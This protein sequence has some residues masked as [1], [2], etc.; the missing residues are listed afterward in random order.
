MCVDSTV[1]YALYVCESCRDEPDDENGCGDHCGLEWADELWPLDDEG[2]WPT[3]K[4]C[5]RAAFLVEPLER[6]RVPVMQALDSDT[7]DDRPAVSV[8]SDLADASPRI[9]GALATVQRLYD[10]TVTAGELLRAME[11]AA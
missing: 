4:C 6:T 3:C 2:S 5:G 1:Q 11:D 9:A 7:W 10:H 8:F